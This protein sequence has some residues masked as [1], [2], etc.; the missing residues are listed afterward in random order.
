MPKKRTELESELAELDSQI[1]N[2]EKVWEDFMPDDYQD[3][4]DRQAELKQE[5][6]ATK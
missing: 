1:A 5:R 4:W 3:Q 6:D 2:I